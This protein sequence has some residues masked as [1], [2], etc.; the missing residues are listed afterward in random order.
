MV[1]DF[2]LIFV[3][4]IFIV[5]VF[6]YFKPTPSPS[7]AGLRLHHWMYGLIGI[8]AALLLGSLPLYAIGIGLFVDELTYLLI[9]GKTHEDN[10]SRSSL[11]GTFFFV[12]A[13]FLLKDYLVFPFQ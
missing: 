1:E 13:V 2:F 10:Y 5:R 12:L 6:L 9:G 8:L 7:I 11:A 3:A 4:T